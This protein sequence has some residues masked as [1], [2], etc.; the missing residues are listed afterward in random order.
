MKVTASTKNAAKL[1]FEAKFALA[2][3]HQEKEIVL[4]SHCFIT[5]TY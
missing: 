2:E 4:K 5:W 3:A 1:R